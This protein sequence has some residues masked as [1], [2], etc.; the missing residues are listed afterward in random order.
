M[1]EIKKLHAGYGKLSVLHDVNIQV[2]KG[3]F[4]ALIGPNGV[5]KTTL[6]RS[7]SGLLPSTSG[8]IT[9]LGTDITRLDAYQINR[10]GISFV[11]ESGDLF[12][13]MKVSENL[14]LGAYTIKD[15]QK[16]IDMRNKIYELFPRLQERKDQLSGT[17]SGGERKMLAIAR[18]LM[19][20]PK[21]V[22][23]DEPSGGLA[24]N[25]VLDVF[26]SLK[27]LSQTGVTIL[28]VEQ[29]V[30]S[31]LKIVDR[32][33]VLEQGRIVLEGPAKAL[34]EDEHVRNSY[35]GLGA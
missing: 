22:M 3:E 15:K 32:A 25:L 9:F 13:G 4:V 34:S 23:I 17:L 19:C 12:A 31:T 28:L 35:L 8:V 26:K 21:L 18:G 33:Y 10:E 14:N 29:N 20:D 5:G 16:I 2:E 27:M 11:T 7:I 30:N 6:M 24:P 1:L